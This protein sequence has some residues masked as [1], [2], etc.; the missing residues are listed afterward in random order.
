MDGL[1]QPVDPERHAGPRRRRVVPLRLVLPNLVTLIALCAGLTAIRMAIEQRFD[2]AVAAIVFAAVLDAVDGRLARY[3]KSTSRFGAELDSLA[4]FV[5]FGVAPALLLY[6]WRL[7]ELGSLGW[8]VAL[9][10][11]ICAGLRLARF[12]AAIADPDAPAWHKDF[13]VGVP[14]P[15]G[16]IAALLPLALWRMGVPVPP[17]AAGLVALYAVAIGLLMVSRFPTLSGKRLGER[18][19]RDAVVPVLVLGVLFVALLVSYMFSVVAAASILYLAHLP[20]AW[21]A[22]KRRA[23]LSAQAAGEGAGADGAGRNGAPG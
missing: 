7:E 8:I 15:A 20:F 2:I 5:D 6:F 10:L 18:I 21:R 3:L 13:F 23:A 16:A 12:N 11:A 9:V 1:F 4:D 19:P 17:E 22:W 14:A